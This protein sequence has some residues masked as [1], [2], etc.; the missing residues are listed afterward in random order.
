[1]IVERLPRGKIVHIGSAAIAP[2]FHKRLPS[3]GP[4]F[5]SQAHHLCFF[6][7]YYWN[8]NEKRPKMNKRGRDWPIFLKKRLSTGTGHSKLYFTHQLSTYRDSVTGPF[9][10]AGSCTEKFESIHGLKMKERRNSCWRPFAGMK[11]LATNK[12]KKFNIWLLC[13]NI[14]FQKNIWGLLS[15]PNVCLAVHGCLTFRSLCC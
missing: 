4:G 8:C 11:R 6:N 13:R 7:L 9:W 3:C 2:W 15:I 10:T 14:I 1:M 5:E 12:N